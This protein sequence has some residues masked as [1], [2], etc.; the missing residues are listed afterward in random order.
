M[1]LVGLHVDAYDLAVGIVAF[2]VVRA[3][4]VEEILQPEDVVESETCQCSLDRTTIMVSEDDTTR[5]D[6]TRVWN[7]KVKSK[8][9]TDLGPGR[10]V[11]L[12]QRHVATGSS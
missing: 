10:T 8:V 9:H 6:T 12:R 11:Q 4:G 3:G 1:G 2:S 7:G 5:H